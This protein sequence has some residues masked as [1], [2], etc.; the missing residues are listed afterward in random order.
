MYKVIRVLWQFHSLNQVMNKRPIWLHYHCC[1]VQMSEK[2]LEAICLVARFL[3]QLLISSFKCLSFIWGSQSS[4]VTESISMPRKVRVADAQSTLSGATGSP[5]S[6]HRGDSC[7]KGSIRHT[8]IWRTTE[9]EVIQV[10]YKVAYP[11]IYSTRTMQAHLLL[12]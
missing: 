3:L 7:L 11:L 2:R 9:K 5:S 10:M 8:G 4:C 1:M 12:L 6:P